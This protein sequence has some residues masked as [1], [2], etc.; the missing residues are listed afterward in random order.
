[1]A[2]NGIVAQQ[3][4]GLR[5]EPARTQ[6]PAIPPPEAIPLDEDGVHYP[7]SDDVGSNRLEQR[8]STNLEF[9]LRKHFRQ[10]GRQVDSAVDLPMYYERGNPRA[11][12]AP[13][14]FVVLDHQP[15]ATPENSSYRFW[16]EGRVPDFVLEVLSPSTASRDKTIKK[17]TYEELG[18]SEY[19]LF[20]PD[21]DRAGP[22]RHDPRKRLQ[23]FYLQEGRYTE[24]PPG[25]DG[26]VESRLMGVSLRTEGVNMRVRSL[27]TG[28]DYLWIDE[29]SQER[30]AAE[31]RAREAQARARKAEARAREASEALDRA[32]AG[33][34][35]QLREAR[36]E[37][38]RLRNRS[39]GRDR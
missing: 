39:R 3:A 31:A 5:P 18:V 28:R 38:E 29:E 35:R 37:I 33:S 2:R 17:D 16:V 10:S 9:A 21:P 34:D 25:P 14:V 20:Q 11:A 26:Q 7:D 27:A 32:L 8:A 24:I 19:F 15:K 36:Q 1:M 30:R 6:F 23:G 22:D 4:P 12:L 13:D